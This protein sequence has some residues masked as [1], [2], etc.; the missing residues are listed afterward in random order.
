MPDTDDGGVYNLTF[1]NEAG[2]FS[3]YFES[4]GMEKIL[5]IQ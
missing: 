1:G 5:V 2:W 4:R 3:I